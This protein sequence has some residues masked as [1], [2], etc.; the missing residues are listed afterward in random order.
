MILMTK[1]NKYWFS[2]FLIKLFYMFFAIFLYA[3]VTV[4]GDN[5]RW[6]SGDIRFPKLMDI[7]TNSSIMM[8]FVGGISSSILGTVFGNLPF[9]ILSYY[10]IYYSVSRLKLNNNRLM[11]LLFLL[12]FPSFGVWSSVAG[13]EAVG[14]FFMGI[15]LGYIIDLI[16]KKR[17][18]INF[19]ELIAIYLLFVFKFQ[20]SVAIFSLLIYIIISDKFKLEGFGKLF[21][22]IFHI[23]SGVIGLWIFKDTLNELSF[24]IPNHFSL[25][26]GSTREN[27]I[28]L[29]NYDVFFNAP[30]GMFIG[31]FGPTFNEILLKPIQGI[32][33]I[34]SC[35]ILLFF[36]Y[37]FFYYLIYVIKTNKVNIYLMSLFCISLFWLLFAHYPFGVLNA[38]SAIRY[39]ENFY[40]FLVVFMY[41]LY[42]RIKTSYC[43]K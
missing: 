26:A 23:I 9:M 29:E 14:V 8:D 43:E 6:M 12:S 21:L 13:K 38:G 25:D 33:F 10:G 37:L 31:F 15:I 34:E 17:Y 4:L 41:F 1:Y 16:N 11:L 40:G 36:M 27:T 28:W 18:K 24:I 20:Y 2:Y 19:I 32:V 3:E 35:I 7:I 30:Y 5:S 42:L 22:F 39:R